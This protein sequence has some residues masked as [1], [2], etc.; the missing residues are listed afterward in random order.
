MLMSLSGSSII[1]PE[2]LHP[3]GGNG[4]GGSGAV[5]AAGNGNSLQTS[6]PSTTPITQPHQQPQ[7]NVKEATLVISNSSTCTL[8]L[9]SSGG[10]FQKKKNLNSSTYTVQFNKETTKTTTSSEVR[11]HYLIITQPFRL[12]YSF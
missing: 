11:F 5:T 12:S 2:A 7:V 1:G 6:Q 3:D 9:Q 10:P 8:K 4:G